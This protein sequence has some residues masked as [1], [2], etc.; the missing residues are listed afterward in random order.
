MIISEEMIV[1]LKLIHG[2]FNTLVFILFCYQGWMG[3]KI[4]IARNSGRY[5]ISSVIKRH[6]KAGPFLSILGVSGYIAGLIV[7][8]LGHDHTHTSTFSPHLALG[9]V[10]VIAILLVFLISRRIK[11]LD[12]F[13]RTIHFFAG[14]CLLCLYILQV[15]F[16]LNILF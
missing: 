16:G 2:S 6:R 7:G 3:L 11:G 15:L 14:L 1:Y 12:S 10:L 9:S 13:W 5:P 8:R 4:R